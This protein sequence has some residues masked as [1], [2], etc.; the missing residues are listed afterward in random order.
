MIEIFVEQIASRAIYT[1][2][3]VLKDNGIDYVF[4]N[5][6]RTFEKSENKKLNYS[7]RHFDEVLQL[8]PAAL[9]FEEKLDKQ[10]ITKSTFGKEECLAF[11]QITD[12]F[13]SIF[14]VLSRM[15]EYGD[16]ATDEHDRFPAEK[17][18]QFQF[19]WLQKMMCERWSHEIIAFLKEHQL[20][21]KTY[22]S[23]EKK[24]IPTFDIDNTFAFKLK[25]GGRK[26]LST[27]KDF[28]KR[29]NARLEARKKVLAGELKDPFD[30]FDLISA[31]ADKGF[32]VQLFW[33]LGDYANFDRNI[34]FSHPEHQAL[35]RNMG[36]K[37]TIGIHPSYKSNTSHESLQKEIG[38]LAQTLGKGITESRQHFLKLRF[39]Q[40]YNQLITHQI[41]DD[42]TMGFASE[43]GFRA[44]TS[45]PFFWFDLQKNVS[46]NLR[47]H[48]FAYMDGTLLEYKHWSIDQAKKEIE[49]LYSE[50]KQFGGE[51]IFLWHNE[52]IGDYGK[53]KGWSE[54]L[55]HTL[56]LNETK[57]NE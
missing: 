27:L 24:I 45:R 8:I 44:G 20:T 35:I 17:S 41:T 56:N 42:F 28:S 19:G 3:F 32:D 1:F 6:Y 55:Y 29:D 43:I 15:E 9:L 7:E 47:I 54:V 21:E 46:T 48:P 4:T 30:T 38:R 49:S 23:R 57:H 39:P 13:A 37:C 5:D 14:Y 25:E 2:D 51:F 31:I 26:W 52:T 11:N 12:P 33:L 18:I 40:T 16:I 34:R 22:L 50:F 53:W 36:K 10:S